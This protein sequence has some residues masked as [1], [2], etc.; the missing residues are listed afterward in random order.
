MQQQG[1]R[2]LQGMELRMAVMHDTLRG[3]TQGTQILTLACQ[4]RK[5]QIE[6]ALECLYTQYQSLQ[7]TIRQEGEDLY[8]V[9]DARFADVP[10]R[11]LQADLDG[12]VDDLI[13]Q[14]VDHPLDRTKALWKIAVIHD[15]R[16]NRMML[17]FS[18]HHALIDAN[19]MNLLAREFLQLLS[20]CM[21][22]HAPA[23]K[24]PVP[25]P[26]AVDEY[27]K[28]PLTTVAPAPTTAAVLRAYTQSSPLA[29]R[30]TAWHCIRLAQ[31]LPARLQQIALAN[32][33]K[34]HSIYSA[35]LCLSLIECGIHELPFTFSTAVSLRFLQRNLPNQMGCYMTIASRHTDQAGDLMALAKTYEK[36]LL[37]SVMNGCLQK[38]PA[39]L[40]ALTADA[41]KL[42]AA[43]IFPSGA[44]I[45]NL[46]KINIQSSYPGLEVQN[47]LMMAN[48]LAGN[49]SMVAQCWEF[50][51]DQYLNL[52]YAAPLL[53]E[54]EVE[55]VAHSLSQRLEQ[56]A[57]GESDGKGGN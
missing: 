38:R 14:E 57:L 12:N 44:G 7:C 46:G 47:Y 19:G 33:I 23:G 26:P 28:E 55:R 41:N 9:P 21:A 34:I 11:Y 37:H 4:A 2:K 25:L 35:A 31:P 30:S 24:S 52:V 17:L 8:F 43:A 45:T 51:G 6:V 5:E 10:R 54:H 53:S 29:E 50:V 1:K 13:R 15:L 49:F 22:G 18:V 32:R 16:Q 20:E 3:S 48:R 39:E 42:P 40:A 27:L 36:E 56:L